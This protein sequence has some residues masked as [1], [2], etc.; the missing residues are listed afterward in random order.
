VAVVGC[1]VHGKALGTVLTDAEV[2][3][4]ENPVGKNINIGVEMETWRGGCVG[5]KSR[6]VP[7]RPRNAIVWSEEGHIKE[8]MH[9][10]SRTYHTC[11]HLT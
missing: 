8:K 2:Y 3:M 7:V 11:L 5:A 9:Q 4:M 1:D 10:L 6:L